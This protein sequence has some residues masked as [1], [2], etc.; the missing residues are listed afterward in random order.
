MP[1]R[2]P[3]PDVEIPDASLYDVIFGGLDAADLDRVAVRDAATGAGPTY[4][5]LR[6]QVDAVA[7]WL[8]AH[9]VGPGDSVA[10]GLPTSVDYVTAFH[11][12]LRSGAA[13]SPMNV[14][15]TVGEIAH[16][17]TAAR[18]KYAIAHPLTLPAVAGAAAQL[19]WSPDRVIVVGGGSE[20]ATVGHPAEV[21]AAHDAAVAAGHTSYGVLLDCPDAPPQLQ[22]DPATHVACIPLS[23]GIGGLMKPVALTH[24]NLVANL[25]QLTPIL[26]QNPVDHVFLTFLPFSHVYALTVT[27]NCALANRFALVTMPQFDLE[28]MLRAIATYRATMV[29]IV[30]LVA[31]LLAGAP[32]I[33]SFDTSSLQFVISGA[34]PLTDEVGNAVAQRL[35]CMVAQ[36]YGMTELSP[37]THVTPFS[38]PDIPPS[39]IGMPIPNVEMR[40]V[41]PITRVDIDVP[42]QGRSGPGEM[43]VRGPN[44]MRGYLDDPEAT[45]QI[46]DAD[47]WLRTGDLVEIT[48][49]GVTW[50]VGRCKE[51]IKAK[52][53][54]VPPAELEAVLRTHPAVVDAGVFGVD[55][56][57]GSGDEAPYAV[58]Q[59]A[60]GATATPIEMIKHVTARVA[61]YKF[62]RSVTF[63][64]ALP[65]LA[66]GSLDRAALRGCVPALNR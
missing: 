60:P 22:I 4:G 39:A 26:T 3:L 42:A 16:Q 14:Q 35:G 48:A 13:A 32:G 65:R 62:L 46:I 19:G 2:G 34:A 50:T 10:L 20:A 44:V 45:A 66:D 53:F 58:I 27:M 5:M 6:A 54:Q 49:D 43:L 17:L 36:G 7:G 55:L 21:S 11:G 52:G 61:K 37:C 57:D 47:G 18:A 31:K 24:R 33:E 9:G 29:T 12:T 8:A 41:D 38:R 15:Y 28:A 30:P 23:S 25:A 40:V 51:L 56:R 64:E 1:I 59:L 63:V